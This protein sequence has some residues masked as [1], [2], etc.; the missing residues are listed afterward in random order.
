MTNF[1][2]ESD[3][4]QSIG[5]QYPLMFAVILSCCASAVT[6]PSESPSPISTSN[7]PT[8]SEDPEPPFDDFPD[9]DEYDDEEQDDYE[10]W[11][12]HDDG[13][14]YAGPPEA[15]PEDLKDESSL[16]D[17]FE[18]APWIDI[19]R[20]IFFVALGFAGLGIGY[21][22]ARFCRG[23][24]VRARVEEDVDEPLIMRDL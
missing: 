2:A 3:R 20:I 16:E 23:R 18:V 1:I 24:A 4:T 15:L 11:N 10:D 8:H 6:P 19:F 7:L 22:S 21:A 14:F 13:H 17:V 5:T 12:M 9:E